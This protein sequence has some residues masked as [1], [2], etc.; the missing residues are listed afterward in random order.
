M[1]EGK[2]ER[3]REQERRGKGNKEKTDTLMEKTREVP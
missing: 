1:S 2:K 3:K